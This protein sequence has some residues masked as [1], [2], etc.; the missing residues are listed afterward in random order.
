MTELLMPKATAIW[1]IDNTG[2]TFKQIG[3]FCN[4]HDLEVQAIADGEIGP[5]MQ[6]FDPIVNGQ[7]TRDEIKKCEDNPNLSLTLAVSKLRIPTSKKKVPRY[8]PLSKRG[9][10]PDAIMWL[11]KHHPELTDPQISKLIGTTKETIGKIRNRTH[12]NINNI[13]AKHP[14]ILGLCSQNDL[15]V[16]IEK[17]GGKLKSPSE[18]LSDTNEIP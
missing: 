10:K 3:D 4:L 18:Q 8:V 5:G 16:A 2:L 15:N 7:L 9:D 17:S 1:L 13:Q 11:V 14:A 12:W 6:G